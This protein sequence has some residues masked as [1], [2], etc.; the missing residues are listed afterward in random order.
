MI[1][2]YPI[3]IEAVDDKGELA[4][5]MRAMDRHAAKIEFY[6]FIGPDNINEL[7]A[8]MRTAVQMLEL[9]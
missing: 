2:V 4:F 7:V 1:K 3:K 9:E 6:A 5:I 8:A